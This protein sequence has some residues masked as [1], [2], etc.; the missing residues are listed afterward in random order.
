MKRKS[1]KSKRFSLFSIYFTFFVDSLSWSIIFP[2]FAPYFLDQHNPLFSP[3]ASLAARTS[4]LGLFLMAFSLGQFLAAPILGEYADKHGRRKALI[5]SVLFTCIGMIIT[6]ISI[7]MYSLVFLFLGRLMTGVFA[8][9][10]SVCLACISDLSST[11]KI[12]VKRFSFL[13]VLTG[14][15]FILGAF[16]GGKLSDANIYPWLSPDVPF[17][18]ASILTFTNFLFV[19]FGFKET[20]SNKPSLQFHFLESF[21][22]IKKVLETKKIKW[23][24]AVYFLFLCAW[25]LIFQ[26]TPVLVVHRYAFTNSQIGNLALFMGI[27]WALGSSVLNK[28]LISRYPSQRILEWC[29][30][31]FTLLCAGIAFPSHLYLTLGILGL[32]TLVGGLAWPH[33]TNVISNTAPKE[34]QGKIL[35]LTQSIQSL[36]M[37]VAPVVGGFSYQIVPGSVFLLAAAACLAASLI[38]T[39]KNR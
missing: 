7:K 25:T 13:S 15:S 9:N 12:K 33:C 31:L 11:E 22:N 26:F 16:L 17:W 27:F 23:I 1:E 20:S 18:L 28:F 24:Y 32:T 39:L 14:I 3:D 29:L 37:A 30:V 2:I 38:Y 35:G 10:L 21:G 6:A 8:S 4:L 5:L 36:S 19:V 34:V